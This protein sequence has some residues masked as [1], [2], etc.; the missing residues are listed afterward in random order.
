MNILHIQKRLKEKGYNPGPLDGLQGRQTVKAIRQFQLD[1]GL[2]VDGIIGPNTWAELF[3]DETFTSPQSPSWYEFA[4]TSFGVAE[5]AGKESNPEILSWA[6]HLDIDYSGDDIPWCGL[7]I[8]YCISTALPY[9]TVPGSPLWARG[10]LKFGKETTPRMGALLVFW[11][12]NPEGPYG[13]VGFYAGETGTHFLVLGGNQGDK[14]SKVFIAK[15]RLL[16][17]RW[18]VSSEHESKFHTSKTGLNA[19]VSSNEA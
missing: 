5:V 13:H 1:W 14:V 18:P 8:G 12:G 6:E 16:A 11:R 17:A 4:M 10:W 19:Q 2:T 7:F 3:D 9:E 15:N